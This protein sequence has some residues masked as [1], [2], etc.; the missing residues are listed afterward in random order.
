MKRQSVRVATFFGPFLVCLALCQ[1]LFAQVNSGTITGTVTDSTGAVVPGV[2]ITV[3]HVAQNVIQTFTTNDHGIYEAK[4]LQIGG[5]T[6]AAERTGFKKIVTTGLDLAVGQVMRVDF[7]LVVGGANETMQVTADASQQL[8]TETSDVGQI[9]NGKQ[10]EDLPLN[11]RNF[12]DLIPLSAGVTTGIQ[13]EANGGYNFNGSRSDQNM[14]LIEGSDDVNVD[15][16]L[17][18]N[19]NIESIQEFQV[20]TGTF[21]AEYGRSAGGI[22]TVKLK[23]GTNTWHGSAFEFLRNDVLDA[24]GYFNNQS[25]DGSG[26]T[27]RYPLRRNQFGGSLGGPIIKSKTFF[28][29]DYQGTRDT[30]Q[31]STIQ[32]VPT[33]LDT[34][35]NFTQDLLP[36]QIL[37]Q[38][39]LTG[40]PYP[41]CNPATFT[42]ATCQVMPSSGTDGIDPIAA[43]VI[44]FY[45]LP[46]RTGTL[47]PG[48]GMINNFSANG[49]TIANSNQ[50]DVKVDHSLTQ[51]DSL[52]AHYTYNQSHSIIPVAF[53]NGLLGP[54]ID[55]GVTLDLQGGTPDTQIQN[56]GVSEVHTFTPRT[57][58]EFRAGFSRNHTLFAS[59]DDGQ[60]LAAEIGL[61]NVNVSPL[62]TGLPWFYL[63]PSP[64]WIGTSPFTPA[65]NGYTSYEFADNLTHLAGK[66]A[67]KMG[68]DL[69]RR[70]DNGSGNFFGKGEYVFVPFFTGNAFADFLSGRPLEIAQDYTP[71]VEGFRVIEYAAYFQDDYKVNRRL[72][73]NLGLRYEIYPGPVEVENRISSLNPVQGVVTLAG[74]DGAPRQLINTGYKNLGPRAGF[75]LALNEKADTVLRG[76]Y[77]ISYANFVDNTEE[78]GLNPPYTQRF[79]IINLAANLDATY[80]VKDG[81]PTQLAPT[82]A[83]FDTNNPAGSWNQTARNAPMPYMQYF[84]LNVQKALPEG[85]VLE[86]GYV[87]S[88]GT[89]LPGENQGNPAPPG[90]PTTETQRQLYYSTVPNVGAITLFENVFSSNYNSLQITASKRFSSGLQFLA[91]FTWGK[92]IDDLSGSSFTGGGDTNP[93]A[94]PQNPLDIAADRA[95]SSFNQL[96]RFVG[97]F[98]YELP[99]G[100]GHAF[101]K[102]WNR[103][104]DGFL[105]G[106]QINGI[107]TL[108]SGQPFSVFASSSATCGCTA[109]DLRANLIGNPKLSHPGP[110]GWFNTAA[111][112]DPVLAYG[113]SPRNLIVGPGYAN[114]D[115]SLFKKFTIRDK[116]HLDFRFE[117]FNVLNRTNFMNPVNSAD[118]TWQSGGI[119]TQNYPARIGQVAVRYSF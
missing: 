63:S 2:T 91:A 59:S 107:L 72:T 79:S 36:G 62:T 56:F 66:H 99:I 32:S 83:N 101:G 64:S 65:L 4:F 28:F 115:A 30:E 29:V 46:N 20:L 34:A 77:G 74:V 84:S 61:A 24:N 114:L 9:I 94:E 95:V 8:K 31:K 67:L 113:D 33:A 97:S 16:N 70:L 49:S 98:G 81:L 6:V 21:S 5:Y 3:T 69:H 88:R 7:Y 96:H 103:V 47:I 45:P 104:A 116:Q 41:G 12:S 108:Q 53:G 17:L 100:R 39:A 106:W 10:V 117:F 86:V 71:N 76:G 38:N 92:S 90:D 82:V 109:G 118:E 85:I 52:S 112:E 42:P 18:A 51:H 68:F 80:Y 44:A 55:C 78:A 35:G 87:G 14:F 60:N 75:A 1:F 93:S 43:K 58:N 25:S 73:L 13:G 119:L 54:C 57:L 11:G 89:H 23:S 27:P 105:G 22:V 19:A 26:P 110:N 15:N 102:A 48:Q 50:F 37:Y 40:Q 111:F